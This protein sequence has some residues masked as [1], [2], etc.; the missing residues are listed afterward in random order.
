MSNHRKSQILSN[1]KHR[2]K[3]KNMVTY[4]SRKTEKVH[5]Q[6][7][8]SK[9]MARLANFPTVAISKNLR[10]IHNP[11]QNSFTGQLLQIVLTSMLARNIFISSTSYFQFWDYM[12]ICLNMEKKTQI[13][14]C[15][16]WCWWDWDL[17]HYSHT[18]S[19]DS[20]ACT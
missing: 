7:P 12:K 11:C 17:H 16:A 1:L 4:Y 10:C 3:L 9:N 19:G 8:I 2:I 6:L 15:M 20:W 5:I 18:P 14:V 13:P